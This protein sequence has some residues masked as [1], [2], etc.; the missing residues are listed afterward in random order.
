[1]CIHFNLEIDSLFLFQVSRDQLL[2][3]P[4]L[5]PVVEV[6]Q[7]HSIPVSLARADR[8]EEKRPLVSLLWLNCNVAKIPPVRIRNKFGL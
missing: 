8:Q 6:C 5:L 3:L 7:E 1:M 2:K 4:D